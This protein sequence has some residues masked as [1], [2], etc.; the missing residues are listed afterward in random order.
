M[1][2]QIPTSTFQKSLK[3]KLQAPS[4]KLQRSSKSQA[5]ISR[6]PRAGEF[7]AREHGNCEQSCALE[8]LNSRAADAIE[9]WNL[10]IFWR[11]VVGI[12]SFP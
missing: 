6:V 10:N 11:L 7:K 9:A 3:L 1:K 8:A 2:F 5:P 12:W 4:S